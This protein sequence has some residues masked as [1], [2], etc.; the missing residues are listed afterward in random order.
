MLGID[1]TVTAKPYLTL[2]NHPDDGH[3]TLLKIGITITIEIEY[4]DN[5][6]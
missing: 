1:V 3:F 5:L 4:V 6:A 2:G